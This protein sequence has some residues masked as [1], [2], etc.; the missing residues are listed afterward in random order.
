M[1]SEY[2]KSLEKLEF[3]DLK[4]LK[5]NDYL[6]IY[7]DDTPLI[8][9]Y[10]I[11]TY[12]P[13]NKRFKA[14]AG[15]INN[16]DRILDEYEIRLYSISKV[17]N[18]NLYTTSDSY[19]GLYNFRISKKDMDSGDIVITNPESPLIQPQKL[20]D[21]IMTRMSKITKRNYG[22]FYEPPLYLKDIKRFKEY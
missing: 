1:N 14:V 15:Y 20:R 18:F 12:D 13:D 7:T 9:I 17:G 8:R 16:I 2:I 4:S 11:L 3:N 22:D 5:E 21:L 19:A 10:G 6:Q